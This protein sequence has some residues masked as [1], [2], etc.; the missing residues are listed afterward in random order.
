MRL[1][2]LTSLLLLILASCNRHAETAPVSI[3]IPYLY[4]IDT[5]KAAIASHPPLSK[6]QQARLNNAV[7][8]YK[9]KQHY[10]QAADSIRSLILESPSA[11]AYF[12]LGTAYLLNHDF[13]QAIDA[14][15]IA[16]KLQ[17]APLYNT[18][19]EL[20]VAWANTAVNDTAQEPENKALLYMQVAIQMGYPNPEKFNE[21]PAFKTFRNKGSVPF[22]YTFRLAMS[23][24][25]DL[26]ATL[27]QDFISGFIQ[28]NL[29]FTIDTN[30]IKQKKFEE[31]DFIKYAYEKYVTEMRGA[32][33]SREGDPNFFY[34]GQVKRDTNYVALIYA[35][36]DNWEAAGQ[37]DMN[38]PP[39]GPQ[40]NM[41]EP[42][43]FF[44]TTYSPQGKIIDKIQIAGQEINTDPLK[45]FSLTA[46]LEFSI[47]DL[48]FNY[49]NNP[50]D[51][52]YE[53]NPIDSVT[54]TSNKFYR[55]NPSGKFEQ[56][57]PHPL[58]YVPSASAVHPGTESATR[59]SAN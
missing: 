26:S 52:G 41:G 49:H 40:S 36:T 20:S 58:A 39:T 56:I 8:L 12:E 47:S 54:V 2:S 29:P 30:W 35:C 5:V 48:Q 16:E 24:R 10:S 51:S 38:N 37:G 57:A 13:K 22:D 55:I 33:F 32:K 14:L 17:Y 1:S 23:G 44:L 11:Q 43:F 42:L 27:F 9:V 59:R 21:D 15:T 50:A 45:Q 34:I 31:N 3:S 28:M 25:K 53:N 7:N 19:Y 46:A 6:D 4:N 18:L